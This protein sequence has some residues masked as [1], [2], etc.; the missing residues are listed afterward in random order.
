MEREYSI[1]NQSYVKQYAQP[2]SYETSVSFFGIW[3]SASRL[4]SIGFCIIFLNFNDFE[5]ISPQM[6]IW[7]QRQYMLSWLCILLRCVWVITYHTDTASVKIENIWGATNLISNNVPWNVSPCRSI[8]IINVIVEPASLTVP[9]ATPELLAQWI[10]C[11]MS[12]HFVAK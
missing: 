10:N 8:S 7:W 1:L 6:Q 3:K 4:I 9:F 11:C 12:I 5:N 2:T